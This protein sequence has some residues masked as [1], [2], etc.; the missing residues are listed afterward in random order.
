[1]TKT[2]N[3]LCSPEEH[4]HTSRTFQAVDPAAVEH[5]AKIFRA[6]GV[7]S[8]LRLVARLAQGRACVG[9]LAG[10][11]GESIATISQR[12]RVL[13]ADN[14]VRRERKGKHIFYFLADKHVQDLVLNGLAHASEPNH[15]AS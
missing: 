1:M 13:R 4:I 9:D 2:A 8:R 7:T 12:L 6:M 3:A 5:C 11:E 15:P 10:A 14:I